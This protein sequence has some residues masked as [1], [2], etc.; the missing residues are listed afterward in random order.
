MFISEI[1][2]I[3]SF[4]KGEEEKLRDKAK[5]TQRISADQKERLILANLKLVIRIAVE[6]KDFGVDLEDLINE[7]NIGL[8]QAVDRY[9]PEK[10]RFPYYASLWIRQKI[11]RFLSN[12]S[13]PIRIPVL[14]R[15]SYSKILKFIASY[16]EKHMHPP[17][18]ET[19]AESLGLSVKRVRTI[20]TSISYFYSLEQ[21]VDSKLSPDDSEN[22]L[23]KII[24]DEKYVSPDICIR[25]KEK[26]VFLNEM[27]AKLNEKEQSVIKNRFGIGCSPLTLAEVGVKI[28]LTRERVRQI[29]EKALA[30]MKDYCSK[31]KI[32][33]F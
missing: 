27:L 19:I 33:L 11:T 30:K 32:E 24:P 7:G 6:Y 29:E 31:N 1:Q 4:S 22:T 12:Y 28:Q 20:L 10:G 15:T 26:M 25:E 14:Q 5:K 8:M 3:P 9:K 17:S 18:E 23:S 2:D 16:K 13:R 21:S